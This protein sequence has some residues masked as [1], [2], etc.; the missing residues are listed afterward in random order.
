MI[1]CQSIFVLSFLIR[2]CLI[3]MLQ[4]NKWVDFT[5]DYPTHMQH[6][7]WLPLQF[8]IYNI[9]PYCT[10]CYLHWRNFRTKKRSPQPQAVQIN[11]TQ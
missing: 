3:A 11:T 10:L 2:V 1:V 6:T 4:N 9:V 7:A 5:R 8:F